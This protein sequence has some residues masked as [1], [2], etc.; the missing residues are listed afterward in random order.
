MSKMFPT[1]SYP[2]FVI[3]MDPKI[4]RHDGVF[5][6]VDPRFYMMLKE[7]ITDFIERQEQKGHSVVQPGTGIPLSKMPKHVEPPNPPPEDPTGPTKIPP[8]FDRFNLN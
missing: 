6:L 8:T 5:T 1:G 4:D 3:C 7:V 2:A